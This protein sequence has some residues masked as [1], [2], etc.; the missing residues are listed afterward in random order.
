MK[1][2]VRIFLLL[3]LLAVLVG[4]C[5]S[6]GNINDKGEFL[7]VKEKGDVGYIEDLENVFGMSP[8]EVNIDEKLALDIGNAIIKSVCSRWDGDVLKNTQ[9]IVYEL[10][11]QDAF[12]I[13]R[14]YP[15]RMGGD[16]NVAISKKD[17][18]ILKM[19]EGE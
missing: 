9:F 8:E 15:D 17:G 3:L 6:N 1:M 4:G 18:A 19:W 5:T 14:W 10:K 11:D 16:Y 2:Q 12:V 13:C 7:G